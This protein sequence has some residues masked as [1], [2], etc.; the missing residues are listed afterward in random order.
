M[1][2]LAAGIDVLVGTPGRIKD[3][4]ERGYLALGAVRYSVLDEADQMLDMGFADD[5]AHILGLC[6]CE[7]GR[8]S[9]TGPRGAPL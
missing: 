4:Q 8:V 6:T 9:D 5:M 2:R 1:S 3:L 7:M